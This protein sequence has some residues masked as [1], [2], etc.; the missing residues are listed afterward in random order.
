MCFQSSH[1]AAGLNPKVKQW[2]WIG[3]IYFKAPV[4][5]AL[6]LFPCIC[7]TLSL[8]ELL[9]D[10]QCF[11][12]ACLLAEQHLARV[13][14][15]KRHCQRLPNLVLNFSFV[16]QSVSL[17]SYSFLGYRAVLTQSKQPRLQAQTLPL[18]FQWLIFS[19]LPFRGTVKLH[20]LV[21]EEEFGRHL[22]NQGH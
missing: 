1:L 2:G 6:L 13:Q 11:H 9:L 14:K 17:I 18:T 10:A 22:R 7:V 15:Y 8:A 19:L 12:R 20:P 16:Q 21:S 3:W 4:W 5:A